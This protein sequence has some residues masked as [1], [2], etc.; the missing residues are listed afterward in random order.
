MDLP[1]IADV[2]EQR[3]A[4]FTQKITEAL[5]ADP[6]DIF[7]SLIEEYER[8]HNVPAVEIAA[9]L[10][11][12]LQGGSPLL[13]KDKHVERRTR[14]RSRQ[15]R[16]RRA[17]RNTKSS[18]SSANLQVAVKTAGLPSL[19]GWPMKTP[20]HS[21]S[22]SATCMASSQATSSVRSPMWRAVGQG[23]RPRRYPRGPYVRRPA[24]GHAEP[25]HAGVE[26]D[27]SRRADAAD[28]SR[29]SRA[30]EAV[31]QAAKAPVGPA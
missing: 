29:E 15:T 26:K 17:L 11:S 4:R 3:V 30:A 20:R 12:L 28:Q 6:S 9:A 13:L 2:N 1:T 19:R 24:E 10:A 16:S 14:Q 18:A 27:S 25:D 7:R 8:E 31:A 23:D 21:G 22:R 5:A